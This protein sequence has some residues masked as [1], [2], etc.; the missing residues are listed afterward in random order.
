MRSLLSDAD[1]FIKAQ[2]ELIAST[3]SLSIKDQILSPKH[4]R[5]LFKALHFQT[6][7][8]KIDFTNSF[9]EDEGLKHFVQALPT[10]KQITSINLT[11]NLITMTGVRYFSNIFDGS[12]DCLPELNTLILDNNPLQN[13]SLA[14]LEKICMNLAQ[15]QTLHL[16]STELTDLQNCDLRFA[17]LTDC[18]LSFN[19]F[20]PTGLLKSIDKLNSCKLEKLTLSFCGTLLNRQ[21]TL[22]R[23]VVDAL[24]K[25][26]DAGSCSNLHDIR[27]CGLNLNDVDC[28]QIVQSLKRSKVLQTL[29]LRDNNLL[30]KVTWKLLLENLSIRT[31]YLEGC[32]ILLNDLN[33]QD[34]DALTKVTS[35]CENVR[36]SL[37]P[38]VSDI[39]QFEMIKR[40]WTSIT[41]Y[42]GKIFRNGQMVW[43][44]TTP[45]N[46]TNDTWEY[47]HS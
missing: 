2:I 9:I 15:L 39:D 30:T 6:N 4:S 34:A 25:M 14:P 47:C 1:P 8:T 45:E 24:T 38:D 13:Q 3:Q 22:E 31:L 40:M 43:L 20:T 44:T 11:G 37:N 35:C 46:I 26:L 19:S 41:Q 12:P 36:I 32:K 23:N 18:D 21:E 16:S 33:E 5:P 7:I 28:W 42:A 10:M 27:L 29:S 17:N